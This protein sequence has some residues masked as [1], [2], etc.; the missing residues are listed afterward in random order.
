[1]KVIA[2]IQRIMLGVIFLFLDS[3]ALFPAT[4]R[5]SPGWC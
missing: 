4:H 2:T 3:M 5:L 1:M